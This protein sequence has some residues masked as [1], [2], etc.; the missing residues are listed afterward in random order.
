MSKIISIIIP[1]FKIF[2]ENYIRE[3]IQQETGLKNFHFV[4][5]KKSI[6]ARKKNIYYHLKVLVSKSEVD[7]EVFSFQPKFQNINKSSRVVHIIGAGPAGLF[8][9]LKCL[10]Y[11]IKPVIIEQGKNVKDRRRDLANITK[12]GVVNP[13]SNY[14][15]G[16]GGAGTYSDGKLYTRSNKR[17][18]VDAILKYLVYFGASSEILIDTHPH[19]GT[20]KLPHIIEKIRE[21][22]IENGGEIYFQHQWIDF[23]LN[24]DKNKIKTIIVKNLVDNQIIEIPCENLIVATGHSARSVYLMLHQKGIYL[25]FKPFAIGVR[26]EHPQDWIDTIQYHCSNNNELL[27]KRTYLPPARYTLVHT[28]NNFSAFSFCMCPGGIIAPCATDVSEVVTNGW[29]PSKRNNPFA[30]SGIVVSIKENVLKDAKNN[31]LAGMY[32]QQSIEQK[33][34]DLGGKNLFAPAQRLTDFI[35]ENTSA[36]LP[37]CSYRP[38]ISSV[39]LKECL[40]EYIFSS[41]K[42]AFIQFDKK[43][44]GF[45]TESAVVV[46]PESRTSSPVRIPRDKNSFQHLQIKNLYPCAE[47]AGYAGGIVSAAIDGVNIVN[48]ISVLS[49]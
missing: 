17:G 45:I 34:F 30:N 20:N 13:H 14:C 1:Y 5:L 42:K 49:F 15:F 32:Y 31:P 29:S 36:S 39:N 44:K 19:I 7:S 43:M 35:S 27:D 37:D 41:L 9:A 11:G 38:G 18:D 22:I 40:P 33:C 8:A 3:T 47:G 26:V 24:N 46:A 21:T 28:E 16:E 48:A 4:I 23:T 25:E 6:D 2:D 10:E 12:K